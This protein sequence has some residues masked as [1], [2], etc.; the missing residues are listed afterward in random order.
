[1]KTAHGET[2]KVTAIQCWNKTLLLQQIRSWTLEHRVQ[3][4][5]IFCSSYI[6]IPLFNDKLRDDTQIYCT[7]VVTSFFFVYLPCHLLN[8]M[9][10]KYTI[11]VQIYFT[12]AQNNTQ[13]V[14]SAMQ[15]CARIWW[16]KKVQPKLKMI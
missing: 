2:L 3:Y 4:R 13:T 15:H 7:L 11:N 10:N 8:K 6:F 14:E 5:N 12:L 1:M 16:S 9:V